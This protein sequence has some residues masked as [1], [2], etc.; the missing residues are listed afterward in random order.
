MAGR[1]IAGYVSVPGNPYLQDDPVTVAGTPLADATPSDIITA[2]RAMIAQ[3]MSL[4]DA[5]TAMCAVI[6][7][8]QRGALILWATS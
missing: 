3:G 5:V 8:S 1:I 2:T 6:T 4:P 7:P